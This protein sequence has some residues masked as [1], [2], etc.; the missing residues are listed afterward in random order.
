MQRQDYIEEILNLI[1]GITEENLVKIIEKN[2]P[3]RFNYIYT[4][5][6]YGISYKEIKV[7]LNGFPLSII[8]KQNLD[9]YKDLYFKVSPKEKLIIYDTLSAAEIHYTPKHVL[10]QILYLREKNLNEMK[11]K[12]NIIN[13]IYKYKKNINP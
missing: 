8:R 7:N 12:D 6:K 10:M 13:D 4:C 5:G 9:D 3:I 11:L 1:N 2:T